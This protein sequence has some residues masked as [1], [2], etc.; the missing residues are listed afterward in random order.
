MF[1]KTELNEKLTAELR[2]IAKSKG[3]LN[4]EELRKA[5]LVEIIAQIA[6]MESAP[7]TE[8]SEPEEVVKTPKLKAAKEPS[9]EKTVRKRIRIPAK[10]DGFTVFRP[11]VI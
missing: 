1:N 5:E 8:S 11:S 7:E 3:I 6:E 4:A 2:E 10:E 9:A